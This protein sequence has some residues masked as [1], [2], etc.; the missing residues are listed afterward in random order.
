M[1]LCNLDVHLLYCGRSGVLRVIIAIIER[2]KCY[3]PL[4]LEE[5]KTKLTYLR[6]LEVKKLEI[7]VA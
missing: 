7:G 1:Y 6:E 2:L 5:I 4:S 3:P